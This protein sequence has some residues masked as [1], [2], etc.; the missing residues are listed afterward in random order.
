VGYIAEGISQIAAFRVKGF[1][2]LVIRSS[3]PTTREF[4]V[5]SG[6]KASYYKE[7]QYRERQQY[8]ALPLDQL[9]IRLEREQS[10]TESE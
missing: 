3:E 1:A 5:T 10:D 6:V 8:K 2:Q 9:S 7:P 4:A